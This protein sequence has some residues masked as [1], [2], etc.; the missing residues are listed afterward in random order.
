MEGHV[1]IDDNA[2]SL[3]LVGLPIVLRA[4]YVHTHGFVVFGALRTLALKTCIAP[5]LIDRQVRVRHPHHPIGNLIGLV[6]QWI[7]GVSH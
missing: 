1:S 4:G 2:T 5:H 3:V 6:L 7:V